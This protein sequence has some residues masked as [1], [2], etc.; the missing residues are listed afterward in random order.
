M[1]IINSVLGYIK[2]K[3][4][5]WYGHLQRMYDERLP[6]KTLEWCPPGRRRKGSSRN[7]WMQEVTK[8]MREKRNNNME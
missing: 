3:Q 1:N 8:G 7:S 6:R 5:N 2:Y 4:L